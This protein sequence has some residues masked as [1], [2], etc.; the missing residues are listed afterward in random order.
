MTAQFSHHKNRQNYNSVYLNIYIFYIK[1][2]D[3]RFSTEW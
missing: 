1:M 2:E 3:L